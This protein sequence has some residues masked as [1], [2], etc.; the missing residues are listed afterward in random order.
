MPAQ[1]SHYQYRR[2]LNGAKDQ[3]NQII[4]PDSIFTKVRAD[5]KDIRI[6]GVTGS[7]DSIEIPFLLDVADEEYQKKAIPFNLINASSIT[8]GYFFT[9]EAPEMNPINEISMD[10]K[11][12]NFDWRVNLEGSHDNKTW[13]PVVSDFRILSI[14][15]HITQFKFTKLV[16]PETKY[17][18]YRLLFK[19]K[20]KPE[21]ASAKVIFNEV[22]KGEVK[23]HKVQS[24]Q[25][26]N[27][28]EL[29]QTVIDVILPVLL[30][31][32]GIDVYTSDSHDYYRPITVKY[33]SDSVKT[34]KGWQYNYKTLTESV[35]S[36]IEKRNFE[37]PS[38]LAT[39]IKIT[40]E[41]QDN[42][43]LIIDSVQVQGIV[44]KLIA[45]FNNDESY[46]LLY[47]KK[48]TL[49]AKYDKKIF[50]GKVPATLNN[51]SVGAEEVV[52][53]EPYQNPFFKYKIWLWIIIC[54]S[55]VIGARYMLKKN[56][57]S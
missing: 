57:V 46:Y 52:L 40:I 24:F 8:L 37:F 54:L 41:N 56:R 10:F 9:F 1:I 25:T 45:K 36:S 48:R 4:L 11:Q 17:R 23:N 53:S 43:P 19:T 12:V 14:R 34:A 7:N 44:H 16:F 6:M 55:L 38:T 22:I 42:L 27:L 49:R 5:L 28:P 20:Q 47:G 2:A 51:C 31:V 35:L 3:W 29:K 39:K 30:P 33:L 26:L 21:L 13:S 32:N 18:F 50:E 15:N